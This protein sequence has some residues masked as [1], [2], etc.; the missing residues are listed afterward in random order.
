M[1]ARLFAFNF[2]QSGGATEPQDNRFQSQWAPATGVNIKGHVFT[3][4]KA[5]PRP[6]QFNQNSEYFYSRMIPLIRL[7]EV[8]YIAAECEPNV[9][10]GFGWLN[11]MR[12]RRGLTLIAS[13]QYASLTSS[14]ARI[15]LNEYQ[16]E[17]YGEG[18]IFF[19]LK[20]RGGAIISAFE[21]GARN[22]AYAYSE[23]LFRPPLPTG[24]LK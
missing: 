19:F 8:Y 6:D 17:F 15:L 3:K 7:S 5:I 24:E 16:R 9:A 22:G 12:P 1:N 13:T 11:Q 14:F 4:Y 2:A 23:A 18:Q 10:D 21:N 20:R